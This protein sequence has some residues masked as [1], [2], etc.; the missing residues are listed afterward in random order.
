MV[1]FLCLF[2]KAFS[3]RNYKTVWFLHNT[4][5]DFAGAS[6]GLN[7]PINLYLSF[8]LPLLIG[9]EWFLSLICTFFWNLFFSLWCYIHEYIVT[10]SMTYIRCHDGI[11][12]SLWITIISSATIQSYDGT[13]QWGFTVNPQ[14]FGHWNISIVVLLWSGHLLPDSQHCSKLLSHM[15]RIS[16]IPCRLPT[17]SQLGKLTGS[18]KWWSLDDPCGPH[19]MMATGTSGT[20]I[21]LYNHVTYWWNF[22]SQL[23]S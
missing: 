19:L 10:H 16:N 13:G 15:L 23:P 3:K 22:R 9:G 5:L 8:A 11:T 21:E 12:G 18:Q 7:R 4:E 20:A 2:S 17:S 14:N 1:K 6:A